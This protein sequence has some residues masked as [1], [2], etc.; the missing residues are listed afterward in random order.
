VCQV[1]NGQ[2]PRTN[3]EAASVKR[4]LSD[5]TVANTVHSLV[6]GHVF[7]AQAR[8]AVEHTSVDCQ[9][10]GSCLGVTS[11]MGG[12]VGLAEPAEMWRGRARVPNTSNRPPAPPP[13]RWLSCLFG[14]P[15]RSH[16]LAGGTSKWAIVGPRAGATLLL[17]LTRPDPDIPPGRPPRLHLG[18]TLALWF[19]VSIL[20]W[21]AIAGALNLFNLMAIE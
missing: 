15:W 19:A 5:D 12:D 3:H 1:H 16:E 6:R 4:R 18:A 11:I 20:M 17:M 13:L 21:A 14:L 9:T 7:T 10:S 8:L 2:G